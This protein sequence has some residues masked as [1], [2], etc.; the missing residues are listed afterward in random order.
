MPFKPQIVFE[1][2]NTAN[3]LYCMTQPAKTALLLTVRVPADTVIP[4]PGVADA[5]TH[6]ETEARDAIDRLQNVGIG[7]R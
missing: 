7:N 4:I 3:Y 1:C 5:K 6:A 2:R